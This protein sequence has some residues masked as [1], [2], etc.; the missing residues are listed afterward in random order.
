MQ[1]VLAGRR[2]SR[3][4]RRCFH[5]MHRLMQSPAP[6]ANAPGRL[7][8]TGGRSRPGGRFA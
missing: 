2:G 1:L 8:D 7:V 4:C 6:T 3:V 5:G